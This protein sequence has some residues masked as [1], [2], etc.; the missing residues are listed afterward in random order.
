MSQLTE[1]VAENL[2]QAQAAGLAR[3]IDL[4][5]QWENLRDKPGRPASN[6]STPDLHG[7]QKAYEAFRV[8]KAEY[9]AQYRASEVPEMTLNTP[10]RVAGW[11]RAVRAVFRKAE[12]GQGP[13]AAIEKAYRMA[14][15]IAVRLKLEPLSRE[16]L[17]GTTDAITSLN[18]VIQWC[19]ALSAPMPLKAVA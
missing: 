9:A 11:C 16:M 14:D 19:D 18:S 5:A 17:S 15:R 8:V 7:R 1:S 10:E 12:A 6:Y 4:Q 13:V 2:P 3:V